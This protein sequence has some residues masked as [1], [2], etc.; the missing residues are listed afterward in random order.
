MNIVKVKNI[1]LGE[2]RP[3]ICVPLT[4]TTTAELAEQAYCA[5]KSGA[6]LVEW[7]IDWFEDVLK[8]DVLNE[9]AGMIRDRI[10]EMPLLITFRRKEEGG[11]GNISLKEYCNLLIHICRSNIADMVDVEMSCGGHIVADILKA[12]KEEGICTVGS[13]HNFQKTPSKEEIISILCK[14]Q[15][16]GFDICKLAVM[17]GSE[18]DVL[19]LLDATLTM[20]EKYA[21]RPLITMSMKKM[22]L[23]SRMAGECFGSCLTFGTAG[24]ASA[25][26]QIDAGELRHVLDL[27]HEE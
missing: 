20:K 22:G 4:G 5:A 1:M 2:G 27:L 18:R 6:D 26:G 9:T 12:A 24:K 23:I 17:P 16:M 13:R 19:T 7:R 25:P 15:E 10:D 3:K 14:M 11:E 21:D 8:Q